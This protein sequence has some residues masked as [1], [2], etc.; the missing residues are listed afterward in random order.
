MKSFLTRLVSPERIDTA[1][2]GA[3]SDL[4]SS[5]ISAALARPSSGAAR[6]RAFSTLRPSDSVST[7]SMAS[8]P[9]L[10]VSRIQTTRPSASAAQGAGLSE[11]E[12]AATDQI[13]QELQE[14]K[15][16]DRRNINAAEGR[17]NRANRAQ[18]RLGQR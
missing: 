18:Q 12:A 11:S 16:D 1:F 13:A 2:F 10:G 8:R 15:Q 7:P 3:R 9:P 6:T 17:Q 5:S 4:A 14:Q